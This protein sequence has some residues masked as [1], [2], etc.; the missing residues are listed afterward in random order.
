MNQLIEM[1]SPRYDLAWGGAIT[2][3]KIQQ[4]KCTTFISKETNPECCVCNYDHCERVKS[5]TKEIWNWKKHTTQDITNYYGIL[6]PS[7]SPY[8]RC[9]IETDLEKLCLVLLGVWSI[10]VPHHIMRMI[11]DADST[12][13][14]KLEKELLQ[15]I[16]DAAVASGNAIAVGKWGN[17]HDCHKI[18]PRSWNKQPIIYKGYGRYNLESH[19]TNYIFFDDGTCDSLDTGEFASK[20]AR[21]IS[22]GARRRIPLITVLVG[23]TLHALESICIDLEKQIPVVV[24]DESGQLANVFCKYLKLTENISKPTPTN[25]RKQTISNDEDGI[26]IAMLDETFP[27]DDEKDKDKSSFVKNTLREA[28][29]PLGK[30]RKSFVDDVRKLYNII[31]EQEYEDK[32]KRFPMGELLS[33]AEERTFGEYLFSLVRCITSSFR[34]NVYV[35][36]IN[37]SS[38]VRETIYHAYIK[39]RDNLSLIKSKHYQIK[40]DQAHLALGWSITNVD[41]NQLLTAS[42]IWNDTTKVK[43]NREYLI[44]ALH[45]NLLVFVSNFVKLDVDITHLFGF[46]ENSLKGAANTS[47]AEFF[48]KNIWSGRHH[49]LKDLY[50]EKIRNNRDPLCFLDQINSKLNFEEED[51]SIIIEKLVGDFMDPLYKNPSKCVL[52]KVHPENNSKEEKIDAEHIYRDLFLWCIL[53]Y[54]LDMAKIF[55]TQMNTR[56]CSAL[57]ASKILKK[58]ADYAPDQAAK[59][60][61]FSKA[62]EFETYAIEFVRCSYLYD[63][64]KACELIMRRVKLYGDTTCLQMAIAADNKKFLYEDACQALLKNICYYMLFAFDPPSDDIPS[65]H[66]TEI[67]TIITVTSMLV[68]EFRQIY[69]QANKSLMGKIYAYFDLGNRM[70]NLF[71]VLPTYLLFYIGL[72]LRFTRTDAN[73]F[74]W[75]RIVMACD[76]EL[77]FIRSVLFIGIAPQLGPKLVMIRKMTNDLLL[78]IFI[79]VV[80]IFGY[81]ITSRS[82][83]AYR[84]IDFDGRQFFRNVVYPVYYFVL[85]KFDDELAQL[86]EMIPLNDDIDREWS[87]FERYSTNDYIRELLDVQA[88]TVANVMTNDIGRGRRFDSIMTE[89]EGMKKSLNRIMAAMEHAK[90]SNLDSPTSENGSGTNTSN[91]IQPQQLPTANT[92]IKSPRRSNHSNND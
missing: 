81:G 64:H 65:I 58:L 82:M 44:D 10:A 7:N 17:I 27:P 22:R 32:G 8:L 33:L 2:R 83:I 24:V 42:K 1:I 41:E 16:S 43:Q 9:D 38:S 91:E 67:L 48:N 78:F 5:Q 40:D 60:T 70:S 63:K 75:A 50:S 13:S 92:R 62:D 25:N 26:D 55:L 79:I 14:V 80:F 89:M 77:W 68:E 12:P 54:R 59:K 53:T 85:G 66:W 56:I 21:Q 23:G 30:H 49:Y 87:D 28:L 52:R 84:T 76:L 29:R 3:L 51:L 72:V 86:D 19:H 74:A 18:W 37:S 47:T 31:R 20:L 46:A 15:S 35:F 57:I 73:G 90:M 34:G 61:L 4:R 39:A 88:D 45:K 6:P 11:G 36:N 69:F 71:L